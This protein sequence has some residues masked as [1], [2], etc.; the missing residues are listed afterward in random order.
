[1]T[2]R[3]GVRRRLRGETERPADRYGRPV[4]EW[5][6]LGPQG[7]STRLGAGFATDRR[8]KVQWFT[9]ADKPPAWLSIGPRHLLVGGYVRE[10]GEALV[11]VSNIEDKPAVA[12]LHIAAF[13]KRFGKD[14]RVL[15]PTVNMPVTWKRKV[16]R[17]NAFVPPNSF[18]VLRIEKARPQ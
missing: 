2:H 8:E 17:V 9:P 7:Q 4:S 13:E 14:F 18:R 16:G 5:P 15:D 12:V 6:A 10:D 11:T 1:M 3:L